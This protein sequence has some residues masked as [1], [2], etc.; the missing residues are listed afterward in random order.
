MV[1]MDKVERIKELTSLLNKYRNSYYNESTSE[2]SDYEYDN[3]FDE[4]KQLENET[5]IIISNSPT[6]T[7]GYEVKSELERVKHSHLMLSLD[8][9]KSTDDLIKFSSGRDCIL[10]LKM[11][12]LTVLNTYDNGELIQSE[13]RGNGE[14]GEIITHNARVFDNLP[15]N[16]PFERKFEIE[17]EAIITQSDFEKINV[18]GK[19]KN[20]RNLASGSVRQLDSNIAKDRHIKFI[21]WKIPFGVT[22]YS[23]GFEIVSK[24]GFEVVPYVKYNSLKDDINEKI[25]ELKSIAKE[26]SFPIDGLVITYDNIEYGKS[27]GVTG[28]HPKH[29][30]AFKFYDEEE[31]TILR[32]IDWTLGR[33][34]ILTPTA[35]FD[36]VELEG[37]EVSRASLHNISVMTNLGIA[38]KGQNISVYKANAIIPQIREADQTYVEFELSFGSN[39]LLPPAKCPVCNGETKIVKENDSEVLMCNN[40][41]CSGKLIGKLSHFVSRNCMDIKGLSENTLEL[42][43]TRGYISSFVDVYRLEKYKKELSTLPKMGARSVSKLLQSIEDSRKTTL[44]KFLAALGVPLCGETTCKDISKYCHGSI[45]EFIFIVS[46]TI[47]EFA[48]ID[49]IGT[50]VVESLDDW[51]TENSEM[52]YELL[53]ELELVI[54]EKEEINTGSDLTG[55][56]VVITGTLNHFSNRDELKAKLESLGAKVGGSVTSKTTV[57]INNDVNSTS[58]KNK[59]ARELNIPILSEEDFLKEYKICIDK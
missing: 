21:A 14:F 5:G 36:P 27:L 24:W 30:L 56:V 13:T 55:L 16:I 46:N 7:V 43:V 47:L 32:D 49:G 39:L 17:G 9:T 35:I 57:L 40:P 6:H 45:D 34:G 1:V 42:L 31:Q 52:V 4:L 59:K 51:W 38:F 25:E 11:D 37:T 12:G 19:Y 58:S 20:C 41:K 44:D 48:S 23:L 18:N 33:T 26:K 22:A 53:E 15:K 10:S 3:L 29:S 28:H 2:I 8:K 50:T 54:E